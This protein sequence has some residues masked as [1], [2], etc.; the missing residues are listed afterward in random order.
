MN[1]AR[2]IIITL[3]MFS[4]T[5]CGSKT[6]HSKDF[7][8]K[9]I[10]VQNPGGVDF[11]VDKEFL[12]SYSAYIKNR[13]KLPIQHSTQQDKKSIL[14]SI[15]NIDT[16]ENATIVDTSDSGWK[17]DYIES[18]TF[19]PRKEIEIN[20]NNTFRKKVTNSSKKI[21]NEIDKNEMDNTLSN[22]IDNDWSKTTKSRTDNKKES[23]KI[24][25]KSNNSLIEFNQIKKPNKQ[26]I[27]IAPSIKMQTKTSSNNAIIIPESKSN[28]DLNRVIKSIN[29]IFPNKKPNH[30]N[31]P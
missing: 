15:D 9:H 28:Q 7:Y 4:V 13:Q 31:N 25:Q 18:G 14:L 8:M 24:P 20:K 11:T 22:E 26:N 27:T 21:S 1:I 19:T 5:S 2:F 6:K 17:N 3:I 29:N 12:K 16:L 30:F 10:P 23:R